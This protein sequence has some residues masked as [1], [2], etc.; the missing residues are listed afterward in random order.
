MNSY[1]VYILLVYVLLLYIYH[2]IFQLFF[3]YTCAGRLCSTIECI[4]CIVVIS[5]TVQKMSLES[6]HGLDLLQ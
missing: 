3:Q 6:T 4:I 1:T 5:V 2:D